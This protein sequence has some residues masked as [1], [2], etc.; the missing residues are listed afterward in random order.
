MPLAPSLF[1][2]YGHPQLFLDPKL[3]VHHAIT[4]HLV[5]LPQAFMPLLAKG[6]KDGNTP[7]YKACIYRAACAHDSQ[8]HPCSDIALA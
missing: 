6:A 3:M 4:S 7:R 1:P 5:C 8:M 2:R